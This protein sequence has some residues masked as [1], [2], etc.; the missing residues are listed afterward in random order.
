[1]DFFKDRCGGYNYCLFSWNFLRPQD[2][3]DETDI[4]GNLGWNINYAAGASTD[5]RWFLFAVDLQS[6]E[7]FRKISH[8]EF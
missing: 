1:M 7:T 5:S 6:Q 4:Q 3:E 2:H 8:G